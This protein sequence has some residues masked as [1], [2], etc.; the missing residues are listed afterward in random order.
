MHNLDVKIL[1]RIIAVSLLAAFPM[2]TSGQT[3]YPKP[4]AETYA[5]EKPEPPPMFGGDTSEKSIVVDKNVNISLCVTQGN[6][7][8]T[9]WNRNEVRVFVKDGSKFAFKVQETNKQNSPSWIMLNSLDA[10]KGKAPVSIECIQ[11][12]EIEIDAP[13]NAKVDIKGQETA[14]TIDSMRVVKVRINGGDIVLRN[15]A[16][17]VTATTF[18]GDVTVDESQGSMSLET[19]TGNIIVFE[20]G[21][22][23]TGDIFKAKTNSGNIAMNRL[24][25]RQ[26]DAN[27]ISGSVSY[28][29]AILTNGTYGLSTSNGSIRLAI[30][31]TSSCQVIATSGF[32][33]FNSEIPIKMETENIEE[34]PVKRVVGKM[35]TGGATL[36]LTTN[37]GSI[38]IKK[39]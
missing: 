3:P 36:K 10:K 33:T 8:I 38:V 6:L 21:P 35:G 37:S 7:K 12:E 34:G 30:P 22:S 14:T 15:I 23:Q 32:G 26:V 11:G 25:F 20:A 16:E 9:G 39:Q 4:Y 18:E 17:G 31:A 1:F 2:L 29:G 13:I 27:S 28:N 24:D 5:A 19:T